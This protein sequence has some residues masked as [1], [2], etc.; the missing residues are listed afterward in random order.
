MEKK[1]IY[2]LGGVV[3][4]V[5]AVFSFSLGKHDAMSPSVSDIPAPTETKET[6]AAVTPTKDAV[7]KGTSNTV[8]PPRPKISSE[9]IIS[10][11]TS[12]C[13]PPLGTVL[14]GTCYRVHMSRPNGGESWCVGKP[15]MV[16]FDVPKTVKSVT[17]A[18]RKRGAASSSPVAEVTTANGVGAYNWIVGSAKSGPL[19]VGSGY[20]IG[21]YANFPIGGDHVVAISDL[22]DGVFTIMNC[23]Q[24]NI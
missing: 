19:P 23:D 4:V 6:Q 1:Y 20:E 12:D 10:T 3:M 18:V 24:R 15:Q 9:K 13:V 16:Y 5:I 17:L 2:I 14:E 8:A 7:A 22:N 21:V 11:D